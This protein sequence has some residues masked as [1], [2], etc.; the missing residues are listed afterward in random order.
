[1][2]WLK[3]WPL[4][5]RNRV[6]WVAP[7][8]LGLAGIASAAEPSDGKTGTPARVAAE[9]QA[10]PIG[11]R[12]AI[13]ETACDVARGLG[14]L[15][16]PILVA[17]RAPNVEGSASKASEL[18]A[19]V[20][21][22]VTA[23]LGATLAPP[24]GVLSLGEARA[25]AST[26]R[27]L[28]FVATEVSGGRLL[29][30]ADAYPA[31]RGFWDRV[32]AAVPG[33][34]SHAVSERRIDGEVGSFLRPVS[35]ASSRPQKVV[36]PADIVAL[37]CG[38]L[39][40][41]GELDV[42][43]VGR[44]RIE[45]GRIRAGR[46]ESMATASWTVLSPV[47]PSPL[48]EPIASVVVSP[49]RHVDVGLTDRRSG[50]RLSSALAAVGLLD[51]PLPWFGVGCLARAGIGL[52][53]PRPC[54]AREPTVVSVGSVTDVDA[55][56]G[57]RVVSADGRARTVVAWR[58]RATSTVVLLDDAGRSV[59]VA[60]VGG[61]I[62]IGDVDFDGVPELVFGADTRT[63]AAD[64]LAVRSWGSDGQLRERLRIPV[65]DGIKALS[66]CP[67]DAARPA[68]IVV[69]TGAGM[70]IVR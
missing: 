41:D 16:G 11:T 52:G 70:W 62:A 21:D 38:D 32:R 69:A 4:A 45:R 17:A 34:L 27:I 39:D 24:R 31:V 2:V 10:C 23:A 6:R 33:P 61:Q 56:A 48:R 40:G 18:A 15:E 37:G 59:R 63:A 51:Q 8:V 14:R 49:G 22:A 7:L 36:A 1:M 3:M 68:Q 60:G 50:V 25:R 55:M 66:V 57:S 67:A 43:A 65:P 64:V 19:R 13:F 58:E 30:T 5:S 54:M 42:V 53:A 29:I 26:A 12:G 28:V 44:R 9:A 47:A 20:A 35:I 46:F